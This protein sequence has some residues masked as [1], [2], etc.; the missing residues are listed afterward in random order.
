MK[1]VHVIILVFGL[2]G[3]SSNVVAQQ[4]DTGKAAFDQ[5]K[6]CACKEVLMI[7][8]ALEK[9]YT[10]TWLEDIIYENGFIVFSKGE[11]RHMWDASK[12][13]FLEKG[14]GYI[15]AYVNQSK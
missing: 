3:L 6:E 9:K 4:I 11:N 14:S 2:L 13:V 12:I 8:G 10:Y 5:I 15:R 7:S 1:N